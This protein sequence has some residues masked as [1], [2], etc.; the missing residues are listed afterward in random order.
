MDV[1]DKVSKINSF[2]AKER[3]FDWEAR[4]MNGPDLIITGS[5]D[6]TYYHLIEIRFVDTIYMNM[7][8]EWHIDTATPFLQLTQ[9]IGIQGQNGKNIYFIDPYIHFKI[10]PSDFPIP[11]YIVAKDV[12]FNTDKVLYYKKKNIEEGERLADWLL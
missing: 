2:I 6:F 8:L 10:S 11:F 5:T 4:M 1:K 7:Q 3:W 12:E 9:D